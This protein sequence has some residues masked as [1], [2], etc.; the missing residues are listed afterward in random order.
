[1]DK[2][3]QVSQF[4]TLVQFGPDEHGCVWQELVDETPVFADCCE[5]AACSGEH[6]D[7]RPVSGVEW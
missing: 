5:D 6:V 1:M 2:E 4:G 7:G 3:K